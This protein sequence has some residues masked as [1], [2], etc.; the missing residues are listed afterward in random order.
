M[1]QT[2][3]AFVGHAV[4]KH[5]T[6]VECAWLFCTAGNQKWIYRNAADSHVQN[7]N[8]L[9]RE[10]VQKTHKSQNFSSRFLM[11]HL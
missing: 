10:I 1:R 4:F 5:D 6:N 9:Q 11:M 3:W 2:T 7:I 8:T